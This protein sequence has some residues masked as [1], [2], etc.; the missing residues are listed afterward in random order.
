MGSC[1]CNWFFTN[2]SAAKKKNFA[3]WV[4]FCCDIVIYQ[5]WV[6]HQF[7]TT[8][9]T[10]SAKSCKHPH[11]RHTETQTVCRSNLFYV[12]QRKKTADWNS[13]TVLLIHIYSATKFPLRHR[14]NG[15]AAIFRSQLFCPF[16][17]WSNS[18]NAFAKTRHPR[19]SAWIADQLS[20]CPQSCTPILN[21]YLIHW[22]SRCLMPC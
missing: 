18:L 14:W 5:M 12:K 6:I 2:C 13:S 9:L 16:S 10:R 3:L 7:S 17:A 21:R 4:S 15:R 1:W 8:H 11:S 20:A 22:P 19:Q